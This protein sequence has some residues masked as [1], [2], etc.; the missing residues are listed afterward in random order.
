MT[1][2][3]TQKSPLPADRDR[4]HLWLE[5]QYWGHRLW[6]QQTPWLV[7]LEFLGAAD[8][9]F[10]QS[11]LFDFDRSLYPSAYSAHG[12]IYLRN[13]LFRNEQFLFR[14]AQHGG[15]NTAAWSR[16]LEDMRENASGLDPGQRDFS[17][18][19]DR[20]DSFQDF[21]ALVRALRS[22]IVESDTNKRWSSRF[23]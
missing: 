14:T 20:F 8:S 10:C 22:C 7:F 23:L 12:R 6:D 4:E 2:L 9:A 13:I 18:L 16:W 19:R 21:A 15:D 11:K 1:Y 5:E 17:Y 3:A